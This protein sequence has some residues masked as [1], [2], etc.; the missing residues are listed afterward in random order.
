MIL[1]NMRCVRACVRVCAESKVRERNTSLWKA[2][3]K[4]KREI[5]ITHVYDLE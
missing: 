1:T 5:A 3:K 2:S 4:E